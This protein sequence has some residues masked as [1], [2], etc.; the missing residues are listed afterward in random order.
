MGVCFL[1]LQVTVCAKAS[2]GLRACQLI[3]VHRN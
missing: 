1:G 2:K 3:K